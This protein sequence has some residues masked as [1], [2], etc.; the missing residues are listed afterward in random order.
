MKSKDSLQN[1]E[2]FYK[3]KGY[4]GKDLRKILEKDKT[5][6]KLVKVRKQKL[7]RNFHLTQAEN[8]K[9]VMSTNEDF[10]ILLKVKQLE[11]IKLTKE[12][13]TIVKLVK[14][15]LEHDW[16]KSLIQTLNKILRKYKIQ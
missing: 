9:Y 11:K 4:S 10:D 2:D 13:K 14:I 8:K 7:T 15:Q 16:R 6:S 3:S 5:W 12:E 1:I